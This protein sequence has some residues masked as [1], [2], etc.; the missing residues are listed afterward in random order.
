MVKTWCA[1]VGLRGNYGSHSLRK[2]WG[3]QQRVLKGKPIPLLMS[4][5][6]HATQSQTLDYLCIQDEEI[7]N[8]YLDME[9]CSRAASGHYW[10]QGL[11]L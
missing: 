10:I 5:F 8:L 2:T 1:E 6:G 3:Y 4:A 9:L 11:L 7:E